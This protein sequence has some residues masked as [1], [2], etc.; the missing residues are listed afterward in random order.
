MF[1]GSNVEEELTLIWKVS[2]Y[3]EGETVGVWRVTCV[4][5]QHTPKD[6]K[7]CN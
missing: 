4:G 6:V 2:P 3:M 7:L 5:S 1:P